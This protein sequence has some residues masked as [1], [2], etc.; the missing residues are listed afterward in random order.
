MYIY[1]ADNVSIGEVFERIIIARD[2]ASWYAIVYILY[3][4]N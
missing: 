2:R 3:Q 4:L 1:I